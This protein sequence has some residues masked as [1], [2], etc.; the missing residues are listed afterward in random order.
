VT[1][2]QQKP[3]TPFPQLDEAFALYGRIFGVIDELD[4]Q[5]HRLT[6]PEF[7]RIYQDPRVLKFFVYDDDTLV[8]IAAMTR[9]LEVWPLISPAYFARHWPDH[10]VRQAIWYVGF[11]GVLP[12]HEN[13]LRHVVGAMYPHIAAS[14]GMAVVD[15]CSYDV[16]TARLADVRDKLLL[17]LNRDS[18]MEVED[19]RGVVVYRFDRP[20]MAN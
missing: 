11:A 19:A 13:R 5:R 20:R 1:L 2:T 14:R 16:A 3:S 17:W 7:L 18:R 10:F 9:V 6:A 4:A 15:F 8:G 12:G